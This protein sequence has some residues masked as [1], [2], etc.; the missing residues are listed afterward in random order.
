MPDRLADLQHAMRVIADA[1]E[2][3]PEECRDL[4]GN[5]LLNIAAEAVTQDVGCTEASRILARLADLPH[6]AC[7]RRLP[8]RS[9]SAASTR[10]DGDHR[11][12]VEAHQSGA[13][14]LASPD[15]WRQLRPV[16]R[17]AAGWPSS[18][19]RRVADRLDRRFL[20]SGLHDCRGMV[21][22]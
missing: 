2:G 14:R 21:G 4:A 22:A 18:R 20:G 16:L 19:L 13:S 15:W 6:V 12:A 17:A 1:V 11:V 3:L 10:D 7:N 8:T 9:P 5:A